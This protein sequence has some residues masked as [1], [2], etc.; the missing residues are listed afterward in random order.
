M[1]NREKLNALGM[2]PGN[3]RVM[4]SI[5]VGVEVGPWSPDSPIASVTAQAVKEA[6]ER[7]RRVVEKESGISVLSV[8]VTRVVCDAVPEG[9]A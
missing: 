1:G 2:E 6:R 4:V 9:G 7:L 5:S 3:A 8:G